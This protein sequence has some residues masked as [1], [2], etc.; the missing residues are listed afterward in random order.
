MTDPAEPE[1]QFVNLTGHVLNIWQGGRPVLTIP[2]ATERGYRLQQVP[3]PADQTIAGIQVTPVSY[4]PDRLPDPQPG[5]WIVVSQLAALGLRMAGVD[6]DDI[7][8]PGPG[9]SDRG[10][11][12]GSRGFM[13]LEKA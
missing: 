6:R 1:D 7:L 9:V 13:R 3:G 4:V 5:V 11:V 2:L 8:F 12:I 10:R